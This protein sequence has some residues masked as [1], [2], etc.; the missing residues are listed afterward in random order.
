MRGDI[1]EMACSASAT[2]TS[3]LLI[4]ELFSLNREALSRK[5]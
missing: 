1:E 4:A 5:I 2:Q 3:Q